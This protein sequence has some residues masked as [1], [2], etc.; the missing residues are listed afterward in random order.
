MTRVDPFISISKNLI[1][2]F[3]ASALIMYSLPGQTKEV[4][5]QYK[6]LTINA[7]L[8]MAEGKDFSD[9]IVLILHG[10]LAHNKMELVVA[11]QQSLLENDIN[12]LAINLSLSLDDRHGMFD[13]TWPHRHRQEDAVAEIGAWVAWL[14]QQGVSDI[15][16]MAHS[17]AANQSMI[18]AVENR[19]PEVTRLVM[20]APGADDVKDSYEERY[21]AIF[22]DTNNLMEQRIA[23]GDGAIPVNDIDF[24]F[25]PKASVTAD[26]FISYYG[27]QSKFRQFHQYLP[28][29]PIPTLVIAGTQDERQPRIKKHVSPFLDDKRLFLV[30][31]ENAG[32]FFR[33]LNIEEAMEAMIDFM[34]QT[35]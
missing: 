30:E 28:R 8:E 27:Q 33:D 35:R 14:R 13:C 6:G 5:Q 4:T 22:D 12:S 9:G 3:F 19:D 26:S 10:M 24:W 21:G 17:R 18:Y 11:S 1:T 29:I 25:C 31:I 16:L 32:H 23:S 7:N 34:E 20:L 2:V 15:T